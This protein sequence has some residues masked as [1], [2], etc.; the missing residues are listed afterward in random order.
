[1]YDKISNGS[2][3]TD[4]KIK[5]GNSISHLINRESEVNKERQLMSIWRNY[6]NGYHDLPINSCF[7]IFESK[8][9]KEACEN[10]YKSLKNT[11]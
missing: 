8:L 5:E 2:T 3:K 7:I 1:M 4:V 6:M 11:L 10:K 9:T